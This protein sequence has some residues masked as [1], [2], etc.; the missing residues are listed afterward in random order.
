MGFSP[1][2]WIFTG[3]MVVFGL[4]MPLMNTPAMTAV[5]ELI[6]EAMMGRMTSFITLLNAVGGPIG[7]A[8]IGPLADHLRLSWM[9]FACGAAGLVFLVVLIVRRGPGS[10]LFAPATGGA[11]PA[12]PARGEEVI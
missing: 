4:T 6:P 10:Q 8:V 9:S 3:I 1:D 7:M 5:Q 11:D 2:I 12:R